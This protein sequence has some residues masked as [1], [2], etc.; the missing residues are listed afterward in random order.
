MIDL[1]DLL[2]PAYEEDQERLDEAERWLCRAAETGDV[3]AM[4]VFG[5]FLYYNVEPEQAVEW[6]QKAADLGNAEAMGGLGDY[7]DFMGEEEESER[8]YRK[9]AELGDGRSKGNL[10][11]LLKM[12]EG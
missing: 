9:G 11:A 10:E 8:W 12:K 4:T 5:Q 6:F 7:Y 3:E 1:A 2:T